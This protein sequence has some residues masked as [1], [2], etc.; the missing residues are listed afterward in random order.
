MADEAD[1]PCRGGT[2]DP[3]ACTLDSEVCLGCGRTARE[4]FGW[5]EMTRG[6]RRAA[7]R[8]AKRR[9][10]ERAAPA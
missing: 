6:Q 9:R 8:R 1:S 7:N 5:R 4:I 2:G 3:N 10:A